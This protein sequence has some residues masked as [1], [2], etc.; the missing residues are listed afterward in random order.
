MM[1]RFEE[2][3]ITYLEDDGPRVELIVADT[4]I[5][6]LHSSRARRFRE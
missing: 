2:I 1:I 6:L 3:R 5:G 4:F